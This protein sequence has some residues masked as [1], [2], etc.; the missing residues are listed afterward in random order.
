MARQR[1]SPR[2]TGLA[3]A[4]ALGAGPSACKRAPETVHL[5]A[6]IS[7]REPLEQL[8]ARY[9]QQHPE[10]RVVTSF[11]ASGDLATQI[12]NGAPVE[13]FASASEAVA[14]RLPAG[15]EA[16]RACV[17]A[18]GQLSLIRRR[19]PHLDGLRWETLL[20][21]PGLR[22]L[23]LGAAPTVPAGVY[24]ETVLERLRM[25]QPLGPRIVR[26]SNVRAVLDLVLH[27][28][29]D[30]AIVYATDLTP[31]VRAAVFVIGPPPGAVD[32][33]VRYPLLRIGA[34][35]MAPRAVGLASFLCSPEAQRVFAA[36][37]FLP[38]SPP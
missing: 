15:L 13:L 8:A 37:G 25:R 20:S 35:P 11:G 12:E 28:E 6:A 30:A 21:H 31:A 2:R 16:R 9:A 24:A 19:E 33:A 7:L 18:Q 23:A 4:F 14:D 1:L 10:L 3:L 27:G 22:R 36:A 32:V 26:G 5:S 29:A 38:P 17:L 34:A